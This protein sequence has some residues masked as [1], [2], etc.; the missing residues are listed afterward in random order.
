MDYLTLCQRARQRA[1]ISGTG[2]DMVTGNSGEMARLVDWIPQAWLD[3]QSAHDTW[4][5]QWREMSVAVAV[6]QMSVSKPEGMSRLVRDRL[7]FDGH[8]LAWHEWRDMPRRE[9]QGTRPSCVSQ[10]PDGAI[11]LWPETLTAGTLTGE[12]YQVPQ[13]LK[14]DRDE[15]WLPEH[16]QEAIIYQAL[17][18]YA[19]YEDAPEV[20]QDALFKVRQYKTRMAAELLPDIELN[21]GPIA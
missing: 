4:L 8:P 18:Y 19:A 13:V 21:V 1:G 10:R 20:Y 17:A 7:M 9:L 12:Y 3:L 16:L 6:G 14:E 11:A 15:P 5:P 2:P